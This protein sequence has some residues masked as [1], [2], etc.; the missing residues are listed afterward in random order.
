MPDLHTLRCYKDL[1]SASDGCTLSTDIS[2]GICSCRPTVKQIVKEVVMSTSKF[3][4]SETHRDRL[5]DGMTQP[6]NCVGPRQLTPRACVHRA[7]SCE[8]V[9][10]Y[11]HKYG[12]VMRGPR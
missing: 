4:E 11:L 2:Y 8:R 7:D 5:Q 1:A 10:L 12:M 6:R 9:L 3:T